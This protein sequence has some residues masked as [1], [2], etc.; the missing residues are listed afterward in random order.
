MSARPHRIP[1][2]LLTV[3]AGVGI[4]WC[5]IAVIVGFSAQ[6]DARPIV[7]LGVFTHDPSAGAIP[8]RVTLRESADD[9]GSGG[10]EA[11]LAWR[12]RSDSGFP[13]PIFRKRFELALRGDAPAGVAPISAEDAQSL[14]QTAFATIP[15]G[16]DEGRIAVRN[17]FLGA[18]VPQGALDELI[19]GNL[20]LDLSV[21]AALVA[22]L[23]SMRELRRR[24]P[25]A[26]G[27]AD[28]TA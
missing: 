14:L 24:R 7:R 25:P 20:L 3:V 13:L 15:A 17:L 9:A 28:I 1:S 21:P 18:I 5:V 10:L 8:W 12:R 23:F 19:V 26:T 27:L 16:A 22:V 6:F 2:W 11:I 4:S